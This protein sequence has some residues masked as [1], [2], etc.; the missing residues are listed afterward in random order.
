MN[1]GLSVARIMISFVHSRIY[2]FELTESTQPGR[3]ARLY[4]INKDFVPLIC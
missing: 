3:N 2:H 4:F 1:K